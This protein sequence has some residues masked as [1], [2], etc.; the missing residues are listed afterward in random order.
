LCCEKPKRIVEDIEPAGKPLLH[1]LSGWRP[2]AVEKMQFA[3]DFSGFLDGSAS[4]PTVFAGIPRRW[5]VRL[6]TGRIAA[7]TTNGVSK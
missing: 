5:V 4:G 7:S 3:P 2:L 1:H 6:L